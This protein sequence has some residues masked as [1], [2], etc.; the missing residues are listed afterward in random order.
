MPA[1]TVRPKK[2]FGFV[3]V[4]ADV[5]TELAAASDRL[6]DREPLLAGE[7]ATV[8]PDEPDE[9]SRFPVSPC[10]AHNRPRLRKA[11]SQIIRVRR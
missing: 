3:V 5:P 1:F 2:P 11:R 10:P 4:D 7:S 9:G 8:W 6:A